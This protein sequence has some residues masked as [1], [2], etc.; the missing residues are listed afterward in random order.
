MTDKPRKP[1]PDGEFR[2]P[3]MKSKFEVGGSEL[4]DEEVNRWETDIKESPVMRLIRKVRELRSRLAQEEYK[5]A[6]SDDALKELREENERLSKQLDDEFDFSGLEDFDH[7]KE[8]S[9]AYMLRISKENERLKA[10]L[11]AVEGHSAT[12]YPKELIEK[13]DRYRKALEEIRDSKPWL[14]HLLDWAK[15]IIGVANKALQEDKNASPST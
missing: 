2:D 7:K 6:M 4:T 8:S 9:L 12:L 1:L 13:A 11:D 15:H 10:E 14:A 3:A 5:R